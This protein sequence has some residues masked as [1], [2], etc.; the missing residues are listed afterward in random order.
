M[1]FQ[2]KSDEDWEM[3]HIVHT[4]TN[5]YFIYWDAFSIF[6]LQY[7]KSCTSM[8]YKIHLIEKSSFKF[9]ETSWE[10]DIEKSRNLEQIVY[11]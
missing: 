7:E 11:Q 4:L 3:G 9:S 2:E 5:R 8:L 1:F 10:S 6:I